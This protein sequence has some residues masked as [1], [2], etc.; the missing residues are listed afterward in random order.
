MNGSLSLS[1]IFVLYESHTLDAGSVCCMKVTRLDTGSVCCIK[2][3]V[4]IQ[5]ECA[6]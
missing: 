5:K 1:N 3:T 4:W 2:V 6:V